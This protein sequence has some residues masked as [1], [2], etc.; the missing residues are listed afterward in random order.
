[1]TRTIVMSKQ[2]TDEAARMDGTLK[3]KVLSFMSKFQSGVDG[4]LD[5]KMPRGT[6]SKDVW[7]ARVDD[8]YRAVLASAG[9][10]TWALLSVR[11]HDAAYDFAGGLRLEINPVTG[12]YD[13]ID[14]SALQRA[15][16]LSTTSV[17]TPEPVVEEAAP[18]AQEPR[19]RAPE[20]EPDWIDL[21][22][23]NLLSVGLDAETARGLDGRVERRTAEEVAENLPTVQGMALLDAIAGRPI[24][25]I[26]AD[27]VAPGPVDVTDARAALKR[28][29]SQMIFVNMEDAQAV[30]AAMSGSLEAWRVWLHPAQRALAD[31]GPW[32]GPFR[33]TGGAGTGKTVTA[34]HR[35]V[36][37]ATQPGLTRTPE[38]RFAPVLFVTY[39][40]NLATAIRSQI[41]T[42]IESGDADEHDR[43]ER[44]RVLRNI[45]VLHLDAVARRIAEM[46]PSLVDLVRRGRALTPDK[47]LPYCVGAVAGT[48]ID[49]TFFR[50]EWELVV[51]ANGITTR[52]E[53]V[54]VPRSGR[55]TRLSRAQRIEVWTC[56]ERL[57]TGLDLARRYTWEQLRD[58]VARALVGGPEPGTA[59]DARANTLAGR[60]GVRHLVVDEA[61]DLTPSHWRMLRALVPSGLDDMFI[62]GDA[63]QRIYGQPV[64]LSHY[65]IE[66]RGR[67]RRLTVNYR[68]SREILRW[69]LGVADSA[70][71]DLDEGIDPLTGERSVFTGP[72]VVRPGD[73]GLP[74]DPD[75]AMVQWIRALLSGE[76]SGGGTIRPRDIAVVRHSRDGVAASKEFLTRAGLE[77]VEVQARADED[78]LGDA[79][80]V[81]TMH[82]AKGLE[83][84]AVVI[85]DGSLIP[86]EEQASGDPQK[87]RLRNLYYVA[88]TRARE[89]LLV[90]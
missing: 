54:R 15:R 17:R 27:Y 41:V 29:V 43:G 4:G 21:D 28:P 35:A 64:R 89:R 10:E 60:M 47:V 32:S 65:G 33:V 77:S 72:S 5:L 20:A 30:E 23:D 26:R 62:A 59:A 49:P 18:P 12:G 31:H 82:R 61:Q 3:Q 19:S 75:Q 42:V 71:D 74:G 39:T 9:A 13:I 48:S 85:R 90:C 58:L 68:T 38:A 79:I 56:I 73:D 45:E 88:A 44:E 14:E 1:M 52:D 80:R 53:Y 87:R 57:T 86:T 46:E 22:A 34:V 67:S 36:H 8:N 2:F 25:E 66:T 16:E 11:T 37:L 83:Y 70:A 51:L 76:D 84:R 69:S 81:M 63:H 6:R 50:D 78:R 7:T 40:A 55:G 24:E